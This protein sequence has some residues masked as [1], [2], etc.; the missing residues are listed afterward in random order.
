M[1]TINGEWIM[2]GC[3]SNDPDCLHSVEDCLSLIHRTGFLP[4][5]AN[6]VPGFS[7]EEHVRAAHW[8]CDDAAKD[9]WIWRMILAEDENIAYGKF[10]NRAA[11]FISKD[12]FPVFANYRRNGYDFDALFEDGFASYRA[13]KIMDVF[14]MDDDSVGKEI[15][16][17]EVKHLAGFG[18]RDDGEAGERGFEGI[19]TDLQMQNYLIMSR[20]AQKKNKKGE[21]YG[22][23]IA[24]LET[25]ETKWGREFVTSAYKE[26]PKESW[27]RIEARLKENFPDAEE[28]CIKKVLGIR[29][30]GET[31]R[32][33]EPKKEKTRLPKEWII[34]SNPKYY[35]IIHAFDHTDTIDWK[36]GS[37]IRQGDTVFLY[38]GAPVSA[39]LYQC[40]VT[41][42]NIPYQYQDK[43]LKITAL[44][45]I[46]LQR[47]YAPDQFTFH[48]LKKDY[49][50]YAV[51][52]PRGVPD[53]LSEALKR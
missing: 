33:P 21:S 40:E 22:W 24:A 48:V 8:W 29:Y 3:S 20:F 13:K 32:L 35:D 49:E 5:F 53:S 37:G 4:L 39:V 7:V 11:G 9:P 23:H 2:Q 25:P 47:R 28:A 34:P 31:V 12:F 36:Q 19:V 15:M 46:R 10:F 44:M 41:E 42:T 26:D 6:S 16:S 18:K 38:V 1:E 50:I 30:P 51:R 43:N 27:R 52:G 14:E 45:K 17:Y